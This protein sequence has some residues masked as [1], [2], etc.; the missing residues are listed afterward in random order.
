MLLRRGFPLP[1]AEVVPE[2]PLTLVLFPGDPTV[3]YNP[4]EIGQSVQEEFAEV[5]GGTAPYTYL[6]TKLSGSSD[7]TNGATGSESIVFTCAGDG[8]TISAFEAEW[9]CTV[10]D[11]ALDSVQEDFVIRFVFGTAEP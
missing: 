5:T 6:W 8:S 4:S 10:E 11:A 2:G 1:A 7:I 9:R 3:K